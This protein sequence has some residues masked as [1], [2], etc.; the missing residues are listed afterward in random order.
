MNAENSQK[1]S[2]NMSQIR[3]KDT[4]P[5]LF[6]RKLLWSMGYRYRL[7]YK[8]LPGKPDLVF[9]GKKKVVFVHGCFWHMHDC[10]SFVWP[11]S[12][13]SFWR[14][15]LEGNASRDRRNQTELL[16]NN[17]T[18][19]II[20]ECAIRESQKMSEATA[21]PSFLEQFLDNAIHQPMEIDNAGL[22]LL[23]TS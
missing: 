9:I 3:G 23:K 17:W 16:K 20:W 14:D 18:F 1:R 8:D 11:K 21:L 5:E 22:H 2:Y 12:N 15:K 6:V 10:P 7:H 19:L 4:K 13:A